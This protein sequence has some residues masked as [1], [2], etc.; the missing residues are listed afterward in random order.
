MPLPVTPRRALLRLLVSRAKL[1]LRGLRFHER[2]ASEIDPARLELIDVSRSV[3]VGMSVVDVIRGSDYQTRSL[4]LALGAGE[5]FRV[6][7]ALG[8]EAVHSSCGGRPSRRRTARL[9]STSKALAERVGH[10]H[11]LGMARLSSGA[12]AY[13]EEHFSAGLEE[14][15]Q[16]EAILREQCTGVIWELDTARIFRPL[17]ALLPGPA[18]RAEQPLRPPL[19]R[20]PRA[21]RPLP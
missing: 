17:G 14:L 12:A 8:W 13:L 21:R 15:D 16:A 5:P 1:R 10:P 18:L 11:A 4:L 6:A 2:D 7:L 9:I 20:G 19:P 3:A